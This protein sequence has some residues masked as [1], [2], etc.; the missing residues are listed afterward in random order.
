[1]A[2]L[3]CLSDVPPP[4]QTQRPHPHAWTESRP[5]LGSG[6]APSPPRPLLLESSLLQTREEKSFSLKPDIFNRLKQHAISGDTDKRLSNT[7][8]ET[9]PSVAG[10]GRAVFYSLRSYCGISELQRIDTHTS[11]MHVVACAHSCTHLLLTFT[12]AGEVP[13]KTRSAGGGGFLRPAEYF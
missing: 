7:L 8:W 9:L 2:A 10:H 13:V 12:I 4:H 5:S 6:F 11:N 1:M 3:R